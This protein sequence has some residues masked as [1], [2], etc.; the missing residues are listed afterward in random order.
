MFTGGYLM[1]IGDPIDGLGDLPKSGK[2]GLPIHRK[3]PSFDELSTST[4]VLF[5]G[6]KVID[7]IEPYAKGG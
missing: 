6:I 1:S 7:L 5:T 4:E 3:A 2:N